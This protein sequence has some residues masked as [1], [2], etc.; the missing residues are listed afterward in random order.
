M[1]VYYKYFVKK[2]QGKDECGARGYGQGAVCD[3]IGCTFMM[4]HIRASAV[5]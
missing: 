2:S 4:N 5:S 1:M 3:F